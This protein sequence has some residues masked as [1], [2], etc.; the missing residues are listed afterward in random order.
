MAWYTN[1]SS[2]KTHDVGSKQ[3]SELG[4]YDMSGNVWEWCWDWNKDYSSESQTN[5]SG[6]ADGSVRVYRGGGRDDSAGYC[7]VAYRGYNYPESRSSSLGF[8]VVRT[9][10]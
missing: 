10:N 2:E 3:S 9:K 6:P 4:L 1:N 7:R 5:P 8:R